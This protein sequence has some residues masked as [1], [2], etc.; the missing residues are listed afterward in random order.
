MKII[1]GQPRAVAEQLGTYQITGWRARAERLKFHYTRCQARDLD[2]EARYGAIGKGS[3][4]AHH[5]KPIATL[6]EDV[7]LTY[8]VAADFAVLSPN[9]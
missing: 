9:C 5:L 3:I 2:F 1:I 7:A 4:E 8:D 6:E